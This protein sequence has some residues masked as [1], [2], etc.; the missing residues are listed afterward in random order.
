MRKWCRN[1]AMCEKMMDFWR[2]RNHWLHPDFDEE[3]RLYKEIFGM[4]TDSD[5]CPGSG[6]QSKSGCCL[7]GVR[8]VAQ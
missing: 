3:E 6:I 7:A 4:V 2:E 1:S 5:S 8:S